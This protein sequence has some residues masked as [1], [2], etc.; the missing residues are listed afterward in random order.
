MYQYSVSSNVYIKCLP[1]AQHK[2]LPRARDGRAGFEKMTVELW[3]YAKEIYV[4]EEKGVDLAIASVWQCQP[5]C[6]LTADRLEGNRSNF[7]GNTTRST[8]TKCDVHGLRQ[9]R[10]THQSNRLLFFVH[11]LIRYAIDDSD[12]PQAAFVE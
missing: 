3:K 2:S 9:E 4:I 7:N 11:F 10:Q 5:S 12:Q 8:L 6:C 1:I